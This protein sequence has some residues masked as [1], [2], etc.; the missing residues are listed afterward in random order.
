MANIR[1][2]GILMKHPNLLNFRGEE[3]PNEMPNAW[4]GAAAG[5]NTGLL[6]LTKNNYKLLWGAGDIWILPDVFFEKYDIFVSF[7][8]AEF[9]PG[10]GNPPA[11]GLKYPN[12]PTDEASVE[13]LNQNLQKAKKYNKIIVFMDINNEIQRNAF[14]KL[15]EDKISLFEELGVH[16][17]LHDP[18]GR[19]C[20][21][22]IKTGYANEINLSE[23]DFNLDG[24]SSP[25]YLNTIDPANTFSKIDIDKIGKDQ[26]Y[27]SARFFM[28][29][30]Q[31]PRISYTNPDK[32]EELKA[33]I[34]AFDK[35]ST[36]YHGVNYIIITDE[37]IDG[38]TLEE[39]NFI[40]VVLNN[41]IAVIPRI[42]LSNKYVIS[43]NKKPRLYSDKNI[44]RISFHKIIS[45]LG[46]N[47]TKRY[48]ED[49]NGAGRPVAAGGRRASRRKSLRQRNL[50]HRR[51]LNRKH[52]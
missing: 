22:L 27:L 5:M 34:R 7:G 29:E 45:R 23:F 47:Y 19:F 21:K 43:F 35:R 50:R 11:N 25:K 6:S 9:G 48:L 3:L 40:S 44:L 10:F 26:S 14:L 20:D 13:V 42:Y 17:D 4:R 33:F 51:T 16:N 12:L 39:A 15:F 1:D 38:L 36:F 46:P 32:L 18:E 41:L 8:M 52:K 30:G 24:F 37:L 49:Y 2:L 31:M 28:N